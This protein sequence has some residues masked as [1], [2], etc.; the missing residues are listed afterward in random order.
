MNQHIANLA[1][2]HNLVDAFPVQQIQPLQGIDVEGSPHLGGVFG[3]DAVKQLFQGNPLAEEVFHCMALVLADA[4]LTGPQ[5]LVDVVALF[6]SRNHLV[7][8][9]LGDVAPVLLEFHGF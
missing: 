4:V 9:L 1:Q 7:N 3:G 8:D 2:G 5:L 6:T